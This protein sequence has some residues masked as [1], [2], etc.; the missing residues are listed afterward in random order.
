LLQASHHFCPEN[1]QAANRS[2]EITTLNH[3][4]L[5]MYNADPVNQLKE[6][7]ACATVSSS[8]FPFN[9]YA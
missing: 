6:L 8:L 4:E 2:N 3:V 1:S 7:T 5:F 9:S